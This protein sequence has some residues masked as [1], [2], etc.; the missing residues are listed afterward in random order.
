M[1][2]IGK[3]LIG[4]RNFFCWNCGDKIVRKEENCPNCGVKYSGK[5]KYNSNSALGA[6]GIGWSVQSRHPSFKN[7]FKKYCIC[8]FT[9]LVGLSILVPTILLLIGDIELDSEGTL[10]IKVVVSMFWVVGI[11][12]LLFQRGKNKPDWD[13]VVGDKKILQKTRT[14]KGNDG[15]KYKESYTEYVVFIRKQDGSLYKLIKENNSTLYEYYRVGDYVH[16]HGNKYLNCFEKY[17]KSLDAVIFCITCGNQCDARSNF[18]ERC[19][20]VLLKGAPVSS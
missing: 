18:C 3:K 13:G 20:S 12:F 6:G 16:Y 14:R 11:L 10:V 5:N 19:G 8:V 2:N 15:R 1:E 4:Y 17:D 9:W 7:Y